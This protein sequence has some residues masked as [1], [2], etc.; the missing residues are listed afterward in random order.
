MMLLHHQK[1]AEFMKGVKT[2]QKS[3]RHKSQLWLKDAKEWND[4]DL[5]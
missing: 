4:F 3:E 2:R 1:R 5:A